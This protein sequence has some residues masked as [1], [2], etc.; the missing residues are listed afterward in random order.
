[1]LVVVVEVKACSCVAADEGS[2]EGVSS[3]ASS[4]TADG[5]VVVVV[6][7]TSRGVDAGSSRGD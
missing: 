7:G 2:A 5:R 1:M 3:L 6:M 4:L